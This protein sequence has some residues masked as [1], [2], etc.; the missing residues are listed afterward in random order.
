MAIAKFMAS[1]LG[2]GVRILAG[3]LLIAWGLGLFGAVDQTTGIIIAVIGLVPLL[4]GVFNVC[5]IAPILGAPFSG[6]K[7]INS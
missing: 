1:P 5:L 6:S 3:V 2:R 4:A 7:V